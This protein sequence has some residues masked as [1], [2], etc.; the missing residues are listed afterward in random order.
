MCNPLFHRRIWPGE[1]RRLK[2]GTLLSEVISRS[3]SFVNPEQK[4]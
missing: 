3:I 4:A 1:K 2:R